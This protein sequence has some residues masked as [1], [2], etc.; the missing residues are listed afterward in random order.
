MTGYVFKR[1]IE[2]GSGDID[3][4][5]HGERQVAFRAVESI[6]GFIRSCRGAAQDAADLY[7]GFLEGGW[8]GGGAGVELIIAY[9]FS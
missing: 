9:S 6:A 4:M 8:S 5:D 2:P 3:Q 7:Q 1:A